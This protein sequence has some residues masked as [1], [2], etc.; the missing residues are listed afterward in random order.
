MTWTIRNYFCHT[1]D[2]KSRVF[3]PLLLQERFRIEAEVAVNR[4][5]MM[6]RLWKYAGREINGSEYILHASVISM[7][8][9]NENIFAAGN[10]YDKYQYK[11]YLQFCAYAYR[12]PYARILTKN[13][14]IEYDYLGNTSEW[15]FQA[16]KNAEKVIKKK[17]FSYGEFCFLFLPPNSR[18]KIGKI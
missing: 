9:F 10:C 3:S 13:L 2:N 11:D 5:N 8:E 12:L 6:T 4:A 14:G 1:I 16:R 18:R 7:V 17:T 15:F